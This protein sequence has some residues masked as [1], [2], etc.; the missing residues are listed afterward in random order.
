MKTSIRTFEAACKYLKLDAAKV[1]PTVTGMPRHHREAITA[2]SK[3]VIIAEALNKEANGG[4]TWKP[5]WRTGKWD[6]Y[7]PWF[8]LSSGSG[9]SYDVCDGMISYSHVGSRLCYFSR[10]VAEYA[11]KRFIKLYKDYFLLK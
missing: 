5:D 9:L 7:Y 2:H 6:K 4:K 8:D 10:E 1:L 11:G 3:L